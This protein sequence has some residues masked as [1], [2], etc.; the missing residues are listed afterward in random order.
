MPS[1][2][3][4]PRT[5]LPPQQ[6]P[7]LYFGFAHLCLLVAFGIVALDPRGVAGFYYHD[8]MLAV[9]HLI[10]LGWITSSILGSLYIV[11]PIALRASLV[12]G[13][14]DHGWFGCVAIGVTGMVTHFWISELR[15]MAWSASLVIIGLCG[16][17]AKISTAL[18][19]API[20]RA[21]K[22]HLGLAFLNFVA[23]ATLGL[24]LGIDRSADVVPGYVMTNLFAHAHLAVLGWATMMV[25]GV[26]YRLLPMVVPAAMP[27][28]PSLYLS[29]ILVETGTLALFIG[30]LRGMAPIA[31][32][33]TV[34]AGIAAFLAHA[35]WML[36][37]RR[38]PPPDATVPDYGA[39][40]VG[41]GLGY[42]VVCC[43]VGLTLGVAAP[44]PWTLRLALAYGVFG[45]VGFVAQLIL[46]LELRL[47]PIL[48]WHT[49]F[50]RSGYTVTG[51]TP[52][53]MPD[54]RLQGLVFLL[55]QLG[56]PA[57]AAGL[58]FTA[59]PF[60][61][62]AAWMLLVGA[63][64]ATWNVIHVVRHGSTQPPQAP[65][66]AARPCSE[67]AGTPRDPPAVGR[68]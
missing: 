51:T 56:V 18:W 23:A 35:V 44:S 32:A 65:S 45:L 22:L 42:L 21:V 2:P 50:A 49:G 20:H 16:V 39:A 11:A 3:R 6:L 66:V 5:A 13:R 36:R 53:R 60:V 67:I 28:G 7:L 62:A 58:F 63:A 14:L 46:G 26:G 24:L 64:L 19:H 12:S 43:G 59:V 29:A 37:R 38:T 57:L 30:L 40:H 33:V 27:S 4:H 41:V 9:V 68:S 31:A 34:V 10:T 17:A 1:G 8:R 15:G 54:R 52:L 61:A 48:V 55:W 25:M 47:I